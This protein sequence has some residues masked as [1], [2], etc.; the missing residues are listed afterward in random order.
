[1]IHLL[2]QSINR[3]VITKEELIC[4]IVAGHLDIVDRREVE[5]Q[6]KLLQE[7][8]PGYISEKLCLSGDVLI[9]LNR[10]SSP[11]SIRAKLVDAV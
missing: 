5:E 7:S 3:P 9:R 11:E 10:S 4:K 6:L 8:A 1:M 2:F